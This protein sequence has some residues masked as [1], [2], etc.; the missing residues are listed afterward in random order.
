[1]NKAV[2][3]EYKE[4]KILISKGNFS[5]VTFKSIAS[6]TNDKKRQTNKHFCCM[7]VAT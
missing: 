3:N 7:N 4:G 1:M 5:A 2:L 6:F